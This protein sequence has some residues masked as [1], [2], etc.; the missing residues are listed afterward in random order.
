MSIT[1][2][3]LTTS[4]IPQIIHLIKY[5]QK[6]SYKEV[7]PQGLINSFSKKYTQE[8]FMRRMNY[9]TFFVAEKSDT[10]EI[11]GII[12]L[13][14]EMVR[15]FY[16]HPQYQKKGVGSSLYQALEVY[17]QKKGL[18][19]LTV[20]SSPLGYPIYV[21]YG[22]KEVRKI[23]KVCDGFTYLDVFMQKSLG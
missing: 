5:V 23:Q 20:E 1:T 18:H 16:V 21:H 13:K 4:D 6:I 19:R 3:L 22:Y 15:G 11:V 17:A 8:A 9:T 10:K 2:R 7:Y 14:E 12:G